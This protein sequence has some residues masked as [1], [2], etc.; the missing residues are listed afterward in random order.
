MIRPLLPILILLLL[1]G[2]FIGDGV[3]LEE[4]GTNNEALELWAN[5]DAEDINR[6]IVKHLSD[7]AIIEDYK[8]L[9]LQENLTPSTAFVKI[10]QKIIDSKFSYNDKSKEKLLFIENLDFGLD[11]LIF[12][13]IREY[14]ALF[15]YRVI[16]EIA[17]V[18]QN[19]N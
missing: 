10:K 4:D 19:K 11:N 2:F 8:R 1:D 3:Y 13:Y 7:I 16:N 6:F 9:I 14:I 18:E 12:H 17:L 5:Q 15:L